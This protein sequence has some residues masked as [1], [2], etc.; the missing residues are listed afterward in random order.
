MDREIKFRGKR[1]DNGEFVYGFVVL[2]DVTAFIS[3]HYHKGE[4]IKVDPRTVGQFTGLHDKNGKELYGKQ[5]VQAN[6]QGWRREFTIEWI[7]DRSRYM[8][9]E[10]SQP[11]ISFDLTAD[12]I[13]NYQVEVL[14]KE[15]SP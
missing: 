1:L 2:N 14:L 11:N 13:I 8:V 4:W 3:Q 5:K 10:G 9:W 6:N 7:N 15:A 12:N